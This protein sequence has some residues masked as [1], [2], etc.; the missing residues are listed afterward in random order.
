MESLLKVLL[1]LGSN[2]G[3]SR[4]V[5]RDC[6]DRLARDGDVL[7]TSRLWR[8]RAIGPSQPDYLNAAA[9]VAWPREPR[10]LLDRCRQLETAAGR[11]RSLEERWGPRCLDL[12]LLMADDLVCRGPV[13]ELPH[14]RF[15]Q[16]RFALEPAAEIAADWVHPFLGLT[17]EELAEE[18][19]RHEPDAILGVMSFEF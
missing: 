15:H 6:L 13:L 12:D 2:Q 17:V 1:G 7:A 10:H 3:Q 19:R 5:F 8:T 9:I 16:R 14:P 18:A 4:A 11:D